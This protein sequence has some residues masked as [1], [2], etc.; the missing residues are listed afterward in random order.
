V[1]FSENADSHVLIRRA[2][3]SE[4]VTS[5]SVV[6]LESS[7]GPFAFLP[8]QANLDYEVM[9]SKYADL[10]V[11]TYHELRTHG[12]GRLNLRSQPI[13]DPHI[14][15]TVKNK[16]SINSK[17]T[18]QF[19]VI[20]VQNIRKSAEKIFTDLNL[21][22]FTIMKGWLRE[23]T[24]IS[25]NSTS[26]IHEGLKRTLLKDKGTESPRDYFIN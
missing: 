1:I 13:L 18:P 15:P 2:A 26:S 7:K 24:S 3:E 23:K 8:T 6:V 17:T 22:D 21:R 19:S 4:K 20:D 9:E 14:T 10:E 5:F 12:T 16:K 11:E 25:N